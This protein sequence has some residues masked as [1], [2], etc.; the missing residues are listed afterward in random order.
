MLKAHGRQGHCHLSAKPVSTGR[1]AQTRVLEK[2]IEGADDRTPNPR[3][4]GTVA[5]DRVAGAR[6]LLDGLIV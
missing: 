2:D 5:D 6:R 1:A 3:G 4:L